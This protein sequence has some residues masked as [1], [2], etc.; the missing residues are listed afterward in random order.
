MP[1]ICGMELGEDAVGSDLRYKTILV[2]GDVGPCRKEPG[3]I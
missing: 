1:R 2:T 3:K